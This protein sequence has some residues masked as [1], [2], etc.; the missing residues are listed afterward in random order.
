MRVL[1]KGMKGPDVR[2][3]QNFLIGRHINVGIVDGDFGKKTEDA[4]REFQKAQG[5]DVDGVVGN[6]TLGEAMKL[7]FAVLDDPLDKSESGPNFPPPPGNLKALSNSE[8]QKIFGKFSFK[9]S[10]LPKNPEHITITDNFVQKNIV[11]V[12]IPQLIGV[13]NV[14]HD[15]KIDFHRLAANQLVKLFEE[16]DKAKLINRILTFDGSFVPR[17]VRGSKTVLSNHS[18][19]STFD[20]N[21]A[22]NRR[23]HMPALV[24][25]EGATRELVTIANENGFFWG[26]HFKKK[27]SIDGMHFEISK[28]IP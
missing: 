28:L 19:G 11:K 6:Q 9:S 26:G 16:W 1:R 20:I 10:P 17:F 7:G 23:G 24:G 4:T 12:P 3:W 13:T 5:L 14:P 25:M 15:G 2:D 21:A 18:F 27:K 8:V 22:F